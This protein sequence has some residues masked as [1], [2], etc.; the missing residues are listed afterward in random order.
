MEKENRQVV[1][2]FAVWYRCRTLSMNVAAILLPAKKT[3][4][5]DNGTE[6]HSLE[7]AKTSGAVNTTMN[8]NGDI[9]MIRRV[10]RL[11]PV[12]VLYGGVV[13]GKSSRL[14]VDA[15]S[16]L[17]SLFSLSDNSMHILSYDNASQPISESITLEDFLKYIERK[18]EE[19]A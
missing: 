11:F 10:D 6:A 9:G 18:R 3:H 13:F 1:S 19:K 2:A 17:T 12:E 4:S 7:V 5:I 14:E 16:V 15:E 8:Q